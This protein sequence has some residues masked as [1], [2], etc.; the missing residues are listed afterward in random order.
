MTKR[1]A[2]KKQSPGVPIFLRVPAEVVRFIDE[3]AAAYCMTRA[4]AAREACKM[5]ADKVR[6]KGVGR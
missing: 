3:Y 6:V 2:V 1:T 5:L 4:Q